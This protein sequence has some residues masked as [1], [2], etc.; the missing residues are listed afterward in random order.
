MHG[1]SSQAPL[2][3]VDHSHLFVDLGVPEAAGSADAQ[4]VPERGAGMGWNEVREWGATSLDK[5]S[6]SGMG[7]EWGATSLDKPSF[8]SATSLDEIA[9]SEGPENRHFALVKLS[10]A[11]LAGRAGPFRPELATSISGIY[12]EPVRPDT[13]L[14]WTHEKASGKRRGP[15]R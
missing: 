2:V 15:I 12:E 11:A 13:L 9:L 4:F 7:W 1:T 10:G 6:F 5:P 3:E 8:S 14:P